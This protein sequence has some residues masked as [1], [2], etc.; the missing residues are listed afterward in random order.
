[1][2]VCIGTDRFVSLRA[3]EFMAFHHDEGP[4]TVWVFS[5]PTEDEM[6]A[7]LT[8]QFGTPGRTTHK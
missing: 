1:M 8:D 7:F 5:R 3:G 6:A 2:V 4:R